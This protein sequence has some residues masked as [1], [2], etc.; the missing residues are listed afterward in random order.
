MPDLAKGFRHRSKQIDLLAEGQMPN[1]FL[2][3]IL[4]FYDNK[5]DVS[6]FGLL[7]KLRLPTQGNSFIAMETP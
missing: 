2:E 7:S 5:N 1:E 4:V 6:Q 3:M